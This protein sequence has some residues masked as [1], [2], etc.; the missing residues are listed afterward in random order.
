M[1]DAFF[2]RMIVVQFILIAIMQRVNQQGIPDPAMRRRI[3]THIATLDIAITALA[4]VI[5]R[6]LTTRFS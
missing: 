3:I 5:V 2:V 1:T 6:A 4:Y